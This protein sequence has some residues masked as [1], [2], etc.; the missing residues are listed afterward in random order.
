MIV[1]LNPL[2]I[3]Q[4]FS[5]ALGLLV[6]LEMMSEKRGETLRLVAVPF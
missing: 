6:E 2:L 1:A 3:V 4:G 5:E